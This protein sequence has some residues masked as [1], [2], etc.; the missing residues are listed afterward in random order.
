MSNRKA[1][2]VG[3]RSTRLNK[4]KLLPPARPS[5]KD[6]LIEAGEQLFGRHGFDGISLREIALAAGQANT[7]AVQY[8]FDD[9][10]GFI[11]A[12][13]ED[14]VKRIEPF[15]GELFKKLRPGSRQ[16]TREILKILW[17]PTMQIRGADGSHTFCRFLLQIMLQLNTVLEPLSRLYESST[18][19]DESL[20]SDFLY[21]HQTVQMLQ[22]QYPDLVA[23]GELRRRMVS[24]NLMFLSTVVAYDNEQLERYGRVETEIDIDLLLKMSVAILKA[25][26]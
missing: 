15:R 9:K 24:I 5:T 7:N 17:L 6:I 16:L 2:S 8:H 11:V 18:P 14:R 22:D 1:G 26:A 10:M 12:I 23:S 19:H 13:L 3:H 4:I 20:T 25:P 21:T